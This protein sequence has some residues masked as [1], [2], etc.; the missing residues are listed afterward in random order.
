MKTFKSSLIALTLLGSVSV[1]ADDSLP[2]AP[3][4]LVEDLT[5]MCVSWA[6]DDGIEQAELKNY[7][8][9]CVNE[10]LEAN[11]YQKVTTV[12]IKQ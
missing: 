2:V 1:L 10:E 4:E 5:E 12:E 9:N 6:K 8:L 11:G 3:A 7:V